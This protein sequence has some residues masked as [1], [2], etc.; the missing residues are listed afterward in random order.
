MAISNQD[1]EA[2]QRALKCTA[3]T[4]GALTTSGHPTEARFDMGLHEA[5]AAHRHISIAP[6]NYDYSG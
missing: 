6:G 2:V 4:A 1:S 3:A 5:Q